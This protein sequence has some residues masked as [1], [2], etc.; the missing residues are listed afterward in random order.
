MKRKRA[1]VVE[2]RRRRYSEIKW[3]R[4]KMTTRKIT[5]KPNFE[6]YNEKEKRINDIKTEDKS[7]E[8]GRKKGWRERRGRGE[9]NKGV[10]VDV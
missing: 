6:V 7:W 2:M 3:E 9:T 10:W 8:I 1:P 5:L 4:R